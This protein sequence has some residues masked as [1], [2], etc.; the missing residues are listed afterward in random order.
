MSEAHLLLKLIN[1][2]GSG[3][4]ALVETPVNGCRSLWQGVQSGIKR[5]DGVKQITAKAHKLKKQHQQIKPV[6]GVNKNEQMYERKQL[7]N[8]SKQNKY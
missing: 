7:D 2:P 8:L 1:H 6:Q 4:S 3:H 5:E